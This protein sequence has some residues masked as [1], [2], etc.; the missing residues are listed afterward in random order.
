[1]SESNDNN[2]MSQDDD[3]PEEVRAYLNVD[4]AQEKEV[5]ERI[6]RRNRKRILIPLSLL[7]ILYVALSFFGDPIKDQHQPKKPQSNEA[8]K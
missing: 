2:A 7:L 1:M 5:F 8:P 4:Q 6:H 3:M